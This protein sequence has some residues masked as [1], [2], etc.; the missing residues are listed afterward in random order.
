MVLVCPLSLCYWGQAPRQWQLGSSPRTLVLQSTP[1]NWTPAMDWNCCLNADRLCCVGCQVRPWKVQWIRD[2]FEQSGK[3][4]RRW[5]W[6]RLDLWKLAPTI[7]ACAT[8]GDQYRINVSWQLHTYTV[9]SLLYG[10]IQCTLGTI[11]GIL[12]SPV[13]FPSYVYSCGSAW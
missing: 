11:R 12:Y 4:C 1:S 5:V 8:S 6:F 13:H 2:H 9:K 3:K 10:Q 7:N